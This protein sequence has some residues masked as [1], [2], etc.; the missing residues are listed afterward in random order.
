MRYT[1]ESSYLDYDD[2]S[3]DAAERD[4]IHE[5]LLTEYAD[6]RAA[7]ATVTDDGS[8][9]RSQRWW[10]LDRAVRAAQQLELERTRLSYGPASAAIV[11]AIVGAR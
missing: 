7:L 4:A 10:I 6:A 8:M 3:A 1:D 2:A 11:A 9:D 5:G